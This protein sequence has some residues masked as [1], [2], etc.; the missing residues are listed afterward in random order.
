MG[1]EVRQ[2]G[3]QCLAAAPDLVNTTRVQVWR[4][5]WTMISYREILQETT[6]QTDTNYMNGVR[7]LRWIAKWLR[8][9]RIKN[10][11]NTQEFVVQV[12]PPS[13]SV[14]HLRTR[15]F[16]P[17][18]EVLRPMPVWR[19]RDA[20]SPFHSS[21]VLRRL[22]CVCVPDAALVSCVF[23]H[24]MVSRVVDVA[25]MHGSKEICMWV[26]PCL[27]WL[28]SCN[29]ANAVLRQGRGGVSGAAAH[30]HHLCLD[31]LLA[32]RHPEQ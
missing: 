25:C 30:R 1:C 24:A 31:N 22:T 21:G 13:S 8:K 29:G 12:C 27:S 2:G 15:V 5:A 19:C 20:G 10:P 23:G 14:S 32:M 11:N 6:W 7:Q 3:Q 26:W 16:C 17:P 28:A 4:L 9:A 18:P